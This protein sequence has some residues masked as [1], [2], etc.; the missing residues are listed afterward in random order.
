MN[1]VTINGIIKF[2]ASNPTKETHS[3]I[4]TDPD[5]PAQRVIL[6]LAIHGVTM[7]FPTRP[8]TEGEWE[9]VSYP[10]L[11]LMNEFLEWYLSNT[12]YEDQENTM[13][14]FRGDVIHSRLTAS[15]VD[16]GY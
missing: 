6:T 10:S 12:T 15:S 14:D 1:D 3:L 7:Y 8:I 11:E 9:P 5:D 13:T 16:I 4:V 2:L